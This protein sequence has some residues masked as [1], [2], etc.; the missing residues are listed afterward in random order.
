M[1]RVRKRKAK[2][3]H[4]LQMKKKHKIIRMKKNIPI[5]ILMSL[6]VLCFS[7][8]NENSSNKTAAK[9]NAQKFDSTD[10]KRDV[11]FVMEAGSGGLMEVDLGNWAVTNGISPEVK[12]FGQNM[13]TDHTNAN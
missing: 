7:C 8:N 9:E 6:I 13:V 5:L 11:N 4:R 2:H 12:E 3:L 1:M 10:V